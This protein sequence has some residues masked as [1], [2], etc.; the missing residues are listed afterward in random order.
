MRHAA[1]NPFYYGIARA[2]CN[3]A[4]R[5]LFRRKFLRNEIKNASGSFVVIA[6]HQTAL[7]F[8]NLIGACRKPMNFVVSR[9]IFGTLPLQG[10]LS[11]LGL[12]PKQQFQT[13]VSDLK[14]MKSVVSSG[15]R[16]AIY[17]A[18]LMCEDGLSTPIPS[19][20]Y[21]FLKW[22][23]T[24][25]YAAR[26]YGSYF[27][28]PK[29]SSALRP[30]RTY[31]D[32]YKLFSAQE[33]AELDEESIR[34]RTEEALLFDA[35]REQEGYRVRFSG[36]KNI[37]G[38][39]NVLYICPH[40]GEEF[41]IRLK[42]KNILQCE[43]CGY[44]QQSDDYAMLHKCSVHGK[45]I[46][47]VSDWSRLIFER[48]LS[49]V[50]TGELVS[51]SSASA[52]RVLEEGTHRFREAGSGTLSLSAEGFRITGELNGERADILVPIKNIP[53]LPFSPGKYLEVQHGSKIYRCILEDGYLVMKF[54]N[55]LKSFHTLSNTAKIN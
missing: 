42:C 53:S 10:F 51:I 33:L 45:E 34:R 31:I 49:S 44:A 15:G 2:V 9:S 23:G 26:S 28:L 17:P 36:C 1:P 50:E 13:E 19:A 4:A 48:V 54:I 29:W 47:Y 55:L 39:E 12:I 25:V 32:I 40:C 27:V 18:G 3:L 41:S 11:K 6:N 16:L 22:L 30:G 8:V 20:T 7:D 46:R 52:F 14:K 43:K 5:L 38:L 37:E 21:K 35:Y 24:D